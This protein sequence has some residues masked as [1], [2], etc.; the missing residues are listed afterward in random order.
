MPATSSATAA[1]TPSRTALN[2]GC[3]APVDTHAVIGRTFASGSCA[4]VLRAVRET[5]R[6]TDAQ[7]PLANVRPMTAWVSTG[8]AQPR[9]SAVL[10]GVFAA[11]ALLVAG[12]GTYG[13]LA[14]SVSQRT[15]EL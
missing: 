2:L 1:N 7:L 10:L 6:R 4:S 3:A 9:F 13:V 5:V 15:K 11:V 14:Y 8:A 12:I